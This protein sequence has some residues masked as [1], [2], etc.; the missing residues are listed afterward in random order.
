MERGKRDIGRHARYGDYHCRLAVQS[1]SF[2]SR[3][4]TLRQARQ[5]GDPLQDLGCLRPL[6]PTPTALYSA[7]NGLPGRSSRQPVATVL[8]SPA[9][10]V[11]AKPT[12]RPCRGEVSAYRC[13]RACLRLRAQTRP[14]PGRLAGWGYT[15]GAYGSRLWG[16]ATLSRL[17]VADDVGARSAN[18]VNQPPAFPSCC[19]GGS[20][21]YK[22]S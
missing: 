6:S 18:S 20:G 2:A 14:L 22:W 17:S 12:A 1:T 19:I 16:S 5:L 21:G 15:H 11:P 10:G 7:R 9:S 3:A 4:G 13:T 8:A